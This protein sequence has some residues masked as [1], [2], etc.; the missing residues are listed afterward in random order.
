MPAFRIEAAIEKHIVPRGKTTIRMAAIF[1][2][3]TGLFIIVFILVAL[4]IIVL[5]PVSSLIGHVDS[6]EK[7]S[8][9]K[10]RLA[11][12]RNDEF[13]LLARAF[14]RL[15]ERVERQTG[16]LITANRELERLSYLDGLTH[17]SNRRMFDNRLDVEWK[18]LGRRDYSLALIMI[19]IDY[20]K[21]Y[22]DEYGHQAG[23]DCLRLIGRTIADALKRP[24][25][26]VARYGGEEFVLLLPNTNLEGALVVAENI[27]RKVESLQMEARSSLVS[28][29]LTISLGVTATDKKS[30][31][32][33]PEALIEAADKALHDAKISGRNRVEFRQVGNQKTH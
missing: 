26:L 17:I 23:D 31:N 32:A 27:R 28:Q 5:K 10:R 7:A 2:V 30:R 14:D 24:S 25:D 8:D 16:D 29:F 18:R 21:F 33:T 20:F 3:V 4:H 12:R 22:N 19:D 6:I 15:I 1:S 13:G 11:S 9:L